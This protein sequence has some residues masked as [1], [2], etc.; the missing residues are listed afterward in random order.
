MR[1][2]LFQTVAFDLRILEGTSASD[3]MP[4]AAV[5]PLVAQGQ[6][7]DW[8]QQLMAVCKDA[9]VSHLAT[10]AA[11]A[12]KALGVSVWKEVVEVADD[13]AQ[14]SGMKMLERKRFSQ[15][16]VEGPGLVSA[17]AP[18]RRNPVQASG[19]AEEE[20]DPFGLGP[21]FI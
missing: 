3:A 6:E 7:V 21:T 12:A 8:R 13:I 11:A 15:R 5:A 2:Q 18:M 1:R 4:A 16:V 20:E 19:E 9:C 10:Q 17:V 14:K